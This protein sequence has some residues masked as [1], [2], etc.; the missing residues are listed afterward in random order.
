MWLSQKLGKLL[1]TLKSRWSLILLLQGSGLMASFALPAWAV[2]AVNLFAE[3][4]PLAAVVAG[5]CGLIVATLCYV[6]WQWAFKIRVRAKYDYR[7]LAGPSPINPL[8]KTFEGKRIY[9]NDFVLPSHTLIDGKTFID[10]EIIGPAILYWYA[11][12]QATENKAPRIDAVYLDPS[13]KFFNGL[14]LQNCIFRGCSFQKITIF[15][16]HGDYEGMRGHPLLNWV[17]LTPDSAIQEEMLLTHQDSN[18]DNQRQP[19]TE[20]ETPP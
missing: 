6:G 12:N 19:N 8:D 14:T 16:G 15:V 2:T 4:T 9:L 20:S 11:N 7:M 10:C 1:S 3:Y 5:F 18:S 17:S 13:I